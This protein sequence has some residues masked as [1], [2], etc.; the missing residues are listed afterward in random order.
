MSKIVF[1]ICVRLFTMKTK[2]Y[3]NES[4]KKVSTARL[5]DDDS[6][7]KD[8]GEED[9]EEKEKEEGDEG[10]SDDKELIIASLPSLNE[11]KK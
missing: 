3:L 7:N 2:T 9:D 11:I 1:C 10:G 8:E 6:N 5:S 4:G